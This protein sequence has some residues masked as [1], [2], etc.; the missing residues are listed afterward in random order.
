MARP[1]HPQQPQT[2]IT[3]GVSTDSVF[4]HNPHLFEQ[5]SLNPASVL[6][7]TRGERLF[8]IAR[9]GIAE[10]S[11][12]AIGL[13][14][15]YWSRTGS[16]TNKF[17]NFFKTSFDAVDGVFKKHI[18]EGYYRTRIHQA[19]SSS[20]ITGTGG[21]LFAPAFY[22]LEHN[23][24]RIVHLFN[25]LFS[26][27]EE[28]T[29]G[30]LRTQASPKPTLFDVLKARFS[31]YFMVSAAFF[32]ADLAMGNNPAGRP[33]INIAEEKSGARA[34]E[35][36]TNIAAKF[37]KT[38]PD[39]IKEIVNEAGKLFGL[40]I[41]A[42]TASITLWTA[43]NKI[44]ATLRVKKSAIDERPVVIDAPCEHHKATTLTDTVRDISS[45]SFVANVPSRMR[46]GYAAMAR[47]ASQTQAAVGV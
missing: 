23:K 31:S 8:K 35:L 37:G 2:H 20:V 9:F 18:G 4:A 3:L 12:L 16:E 28:V 1:T 27:A 46:E 5:V 11:V 14:T 15:A 26:T 32:G 44:F 39:K 6:P 24:G 21:T 47:D 43:L 7:E 13:V 41:F 45:P 42:T 22:A 30:D 25:R 38:V 17:I 40:D 19:I 33:Y 29:M 34:Q 36:F 10:T